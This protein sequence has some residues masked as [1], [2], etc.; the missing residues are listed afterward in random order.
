MK[1]SMKLTVLPAEQTKAVTKSAT[2]ELEISWQKTTAAKRDKAFQIE[3]YIAAIV[4]QCKQ[5]VKLSTA[6]R[7]YESR[8]KAGGVDSSL[9][10]LGK[11]LGRD[12]KQPST[13]AVRRWV[14][15]YLITTA[16]H[17]H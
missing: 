3:R 8:L 11:T 2:S 4:A 13:P 9:Y 14:K 17:Q 15:S 1:V 16:T 5:G 10:I 6:C 12:C 7:D